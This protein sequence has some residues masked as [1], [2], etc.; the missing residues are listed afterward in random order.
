MK[1]SHWCCVA[2]KTKCALSPRRTRRWQA[3]TVKWSSFKLWSSGTSS[4]TCPR[5]S[6]E[7]F[8]ATIP[9]SRISEEEQSVRSCKVIETFY[10]YDEDVLVDSDG[11]SL[12]FH[13]DRTPDTEPEEEA[14]LRYRQLTQEYQALQRAYALLAQ[15]SGE[16]Y[17][18]EKEIK[19]WV[20]IKAE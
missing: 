18:A 8:A 12:S 11:S 13:T 10:G 5:S 19:K 17:D 20:T 3:W 6:G 7:R 2:L 15:T 1:N 14:E 4:T 16:D 9:T